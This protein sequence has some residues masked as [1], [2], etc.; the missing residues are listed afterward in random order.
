[1]IN[2]FVLLCAIGWS[3]NV[4]YSAA[5]EDTPVVGWYLGVSAGVT[6]PKSTNFANAQSW[7]YDAGY[8]FENFSSELTYSYLG[9]FRHDNAAATDVR[10]WGATLAVLPRFEVNS[11]FALEGLF[12]VQRWRADSQLLGKHFGRDEGTSATFGAGMV[13]QIKGGVAVSL[14]WQRYNNISGTDLSQSALGIQYVFR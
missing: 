14:R 3:V 5:A 11:W 1:M 7:N 9:R 6:A 4:G 8:R 13:C 12:G 10:V 2:R